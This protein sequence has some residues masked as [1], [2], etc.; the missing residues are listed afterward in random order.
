MEYSVVFSYTLSIAGNRGVGIQ[1][2]DNLRPIES[3]EL[4]NLAEFF[5]LCS[6]R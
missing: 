6:S 5:T 1:G 4:G 2:V 3:T